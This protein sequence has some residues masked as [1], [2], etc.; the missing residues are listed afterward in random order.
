MATNSK[1]F[2]HSQQSISSPFSQEIVKIANDDDFSC[3]YHLPANNDRPHQSSFIHNSSSAYQIL[4]SQYHGARFLLCFEG[5]G[6]H[7]VLTPYFLH[8]SVYVVQ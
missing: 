8:V 7:M 5:R 6:F 1:Y 2:Y 3:P 4:A